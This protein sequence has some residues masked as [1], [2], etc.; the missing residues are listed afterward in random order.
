MDIQGSVGKILERGEVVAEVFYNKL[1]DR[2]PRFRAYFADVNLRRQAVLL[3]MALKLI[4][5]H[6]SHDYPSI[7][8]YLKILGHRHRERLNVPAELFSPFGDCLL[9]AI[10]EF[11]G[12]EWDQALEDQWRTAIDEAIALML[13]DQHISDE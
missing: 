6:Y 8:S 9:M 3:T 4:E 2:H 12:S 1:F 7:R 13:E 11:H 5:Q 10:Q